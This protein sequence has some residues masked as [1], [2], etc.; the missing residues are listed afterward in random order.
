MFSPSYDGD[1]CYQPSHRHP[2]QR[3]W[4]QTQV[5]ITLIMMMNVILL[6]IM[7]MNMILMMTMIAR[8]DHLCTAHFRQLEDLISTDSTKEEFEEQLNSGKG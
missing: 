5:I 1:N 6:H 8:P 3:G 7:M 2:G 4:R